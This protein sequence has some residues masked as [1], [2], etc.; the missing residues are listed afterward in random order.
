L[1]S[2]P[3]AN[4]SIKDAAR[5]RNLFVPSIPL[6][7]NDPELESF[8]ICG[9]GGEPTQ[10]TDTQPFACERIGLTQEYT[11]A[12]AIS[13]FGSIHSAKLAIQFG[14]KQASVSQR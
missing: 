1:I 13:K 4:V 2:W 5:K 3:A 12:E 14:I 11:N 10:F 6:L 9:G 8:Y 7:S